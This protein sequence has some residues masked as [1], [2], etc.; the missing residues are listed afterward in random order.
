MQTECL[1]LTNIKVSVM[2]KAMRNME[3]MKHTDP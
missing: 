3:E 2:K 1:R